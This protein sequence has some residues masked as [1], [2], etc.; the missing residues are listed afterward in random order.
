MATQSIT[1]I[2]CT[3]YG[4]RCLT[5]DTFISARK[6]SLRR[7]CF[8]G[9]LSVHR[10]GSA[11]RGVCIQ[12]GFSSRGGSAFKGDQ[13]PGGLGRPPPLDTMGYGRYGIR[14][15]HILL[16]WILVINDVSLISV[17]TFYFPLNTRS[18]NRTS[19]MTNL[20]SCPIYSTLWV[21]HIKKSAF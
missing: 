2:A 19:P 21:N 11:S 4:F 9:C 6:W 18:S 20:Y 1:I 17:E 13:H 16:E 10:E 3:F 7:L 14:A 15:V 8:H 5:H 12:G